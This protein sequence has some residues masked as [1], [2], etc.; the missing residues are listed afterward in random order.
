MKT[1]QL[2][3]IIVVVLFTF[4]GLSQD[5]EKEISTNP[6]APFNNQPFPSG[7]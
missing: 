6:V 5:C 2:S 4:S 3:F 1:L 7:R